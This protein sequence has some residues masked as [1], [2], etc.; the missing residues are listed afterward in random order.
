MD[1]AKHIETHAPLHVVLGAG[2]IG[3]LVAARLLDRGYRVRMV[4]RGRF[5][6]VPAGVETMSGDVSDPKAA[7][8]LMR[9]AA[10]VYNTVNPPYTDWPQKLMPLVRGV[11]SGAAR[12]GAHLVSLDNLYMYGQ[13]PGG[14]MT[15]DCPIAPCSKKGELRAKA[16]AEMI[17][18]RD[19]G[20]LALTIGRA[21]D[22]IGP[23]ATLSAVFGDRFWPRALSGKAGEVNGD[24]DQPHS[25]SYVPDVA[26]ALV[27]LGTDDRAKN[28]LWHLPVDT[29]LTTR[30]VMTRIG[31]TVGRDLRAKC[32]PN[33]V[34]RG[35]GIFSPILTELAEMSYQWRAPFV[36]DDTRFRST[37]GKGATPWDEVIPAT[38]AWARGH[39]APAI[40]RAA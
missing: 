9:G 17:A 4:R 5:Q 19:R 34:L 35:L 31:L 40:P 28:G 33:W 36:L 27:T 2:Q 29:A 11:V 8:E 12:A 7:A 32:I 15:E 3:P 22:F 14:R 23:G 24:P 13:A 25:Y 16:A 39:Y 18:A 1:P 20:D 10:V 26:D 38:V 37:F 6:D 30:E 21:S